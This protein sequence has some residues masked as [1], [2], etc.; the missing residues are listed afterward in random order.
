MPILRRS[1]RALTLSIILGV[2]AA[3]SPLAVHHGRINGD[4][5]GWSVAP[6]GDVNGDGI[7]EYLVGAPHDDTININNGSVH[8][9]DG[10]THNVVHIFDG[11]AMNDHFGWTVSE[12]GDVNGDGRADIL[13]GN[14]LS[15]LNAI[16]AGSVHVYDGVTGMELY[17]L[18][19]AVAWDS[20]G[21]GLCPL[22]D[23]DGDGAA[24]FAFGTPYHDLILAGGGRVDIVSGATGTIISTI[25]PPTGGAHMGFALACPGDITGDGINDLLV[26]SPI[27]NAFGIDSGVVRLHAMPSGTIVTTYLPSIP[28]EHLGRALDVIPDLDGDGFDDFIAGAPA[29]IPFGTD[30]GKAYVFSTAT[31]TI[32]HTHLGN[33]LGGK[34]G[35]AVAGMH[36][37]T[38]DGVPDYMVGAPW[39]SGG[40]VRRGVVNLYSGA[41]GALARQFVGSANDESL[42]HGVS[43]LPDANGD[44]LAELIIGG[45]EYQSPTSITGPGVT[46]VHAGTPITE[47][48]LLDLGG[49]C[50]F[51]GGTP[52]ILSGDLPLIGTSPIISVTNA[53]PGGTVT[54]YVDLP[55]NTP[56]AVA[57]GCLAY[58]GPSPLTSVATGT[59][60]GGGELTFP[61]LLPEDLSLVGL[62]G[63]IQAATTSPSI[64]ISNAVLWVAGS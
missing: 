30:S 38:G 54:V 24:D 50:D 8:V 25:N 7:S 40:G 57:P 62:S 32:L 61:I 16:G 34:F 15:D 63:Y 59:A 14:T 53:V 42:G 1:V 35:H 5:F 45:I 23:I 33:S 22:G 41:T 28:G 48:S 36:D 26:G 17:A 13:V 21:T 39:A 11:P 47:A 43:D 46:R 64:Q 31:G 52:P 18:H 19:G 55:T 56:W 4:Q 12:L 2:C 51:S 27:A 20:A 37:A 3:Q 60:D 6:A 49:G 44:G 29:A 9:F 58:V 10:A